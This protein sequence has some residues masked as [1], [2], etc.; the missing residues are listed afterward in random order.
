[1]LSEEGLHP[2]PQA[3]FASHMIAELTRVD[4]QSIVCRFLQT[5]RALCVSLHHFYRE[6][7]KKRGVKNYARFG[8]FYGP[9]PSKS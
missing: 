1:M 8:Q 4:D 6:L 9:N 5:K 7:A 2:L 3:R